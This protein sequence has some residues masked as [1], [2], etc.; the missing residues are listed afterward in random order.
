MSR[1]VKLSLCKLCEQQLYGMVTPFFIAPQEKDFN[2]HK[3]WLVKSLKTIP[4][5]SHHDGIILAELKAHINK[6]PPRV[7]TSGT[8]Q[9]GEIWTRRPLHS[10]PNSSV[11][12]KTRIS[13]RTGRTWRPHETPEELNTFQANQHATQYSLTDH[14]SKTHVLQEKGYLKGV[15]PHHVPRAPRGPWP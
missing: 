8:R 14:R 7:A 10:P 12:L 2:L 11:D 15:R 13:M 6:K 3:P 5:I 9:T 1:R 4:G